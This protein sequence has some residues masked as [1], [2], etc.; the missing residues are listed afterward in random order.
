MRAQLHIRHARR[1]RQSLD[2][3]FAPDVMMPV[4]GGGGQRA[5][6]ILVIGSGGREH[7]IAWRLAHEGHKIYGWPGN[8]GIAQVAEIGE[9]VDP[10]LIVVGPEA[11]LV[12]GIVDRYRARGLAVVG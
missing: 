6:K 5:V 1:R 8:P 4:I 3:G 2:S 11:P 12:D 10:D 9:P 7:A